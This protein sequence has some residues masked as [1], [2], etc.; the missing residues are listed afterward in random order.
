M[1]KHTVVWLDHKEARIFG[2]DAGEA[3]EAKVHAP[4]FV[5]RH[6]HE[7]DRARDNQED[8]KKFFKEVA[9]AL[10]DAEGILVVGPSFAKLE[11]LRYVQ[12]HDGGLDKKILGLETVDHPT[13]RQIVAYARAYFGQS[14][15]IPSLE[16]AAK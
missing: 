4:H 5:H 11:F 6:P 10:K 13:D 1:S 3:S 12:M 7:S 14:S 9:T 8:N 2:I 15:S 16:L